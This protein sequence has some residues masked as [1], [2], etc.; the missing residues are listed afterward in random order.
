MFLYRAQ[1]NMIVVHVAG[2]PGSGKSTLGAALAQV[3]GVHVLDLDDVN[4]AFAESNN[5]VPLTR[6]D[7]ARFQ[8][9]YQAHLDSLIEDVRSSGAQ[10]LVFVGINGAILG[11]WPGKQFLT[12]DVHAS[13]SYCL[14][15]PVALNVQRW[16]QRDMPELIDELCARLKTDVATYTK[17]RDDERN[18][19][20]A[21]EDEFHALLRDFRPSQRTSD[22]Q[23]FRKYFMKQGFTFANAEQIEDAVKALL[24]SLVHIP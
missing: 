17:Y 11:T 5:Y 20:R 2:A 23:T 13:S 12:V 9:L 7:P 6:S 19:V 1:I 16:I 21:Y 15:T 24:Q 3:K 8:S 18:F 4:S 14:D 10:V 22:I